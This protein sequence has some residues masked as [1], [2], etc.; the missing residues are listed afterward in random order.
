M[1]KVFV[2]EKVI[3]FTNNEESH[4]HL[5]NCLVI[6]YFNPDITPTIVNLL[7]NCRKT[8][9]VVVLV[10][11]YKESFIQ[12]KSC[13]NIIEAAGGIVSNKKEEKLFIYRLDKWD[14][15][16]GK[17]E[18]GEKFEE[19]AIREI[20]EECGISDLTIQKSL[21]DTFHIYQLK[22]KLILKQTHWFQIES[23]YSGELIPQ[24]EENIAKVEWFNDQQIKYEVIK[25]TYLSI[26]E[27]L[28]I[29][30]YL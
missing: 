2:N 24:T 26:T 5:N 17:I 23:N 4:H 20:E 22:E 15:P 27:L 3:I 11:D 14:L 1:Y 25:N 18:K 21:T 9:I 12:F 16:K 19:A 29:S 28:S 8:H 10:P 7:F 6:N 13:F 30:G